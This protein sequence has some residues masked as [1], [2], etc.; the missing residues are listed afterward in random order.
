MFTYS[1]L[2]TGP[3]AVGKTCMCDLLSNYLNEENKYN[4]FKVP[5][6]LVREEG[7]SLLKLYLEKTISNTT[8]QNYILDY[9]DKALLNLEDNLKK[10]TKDNIVIYE[11]VPDDSVLCFANLANIRGEFSNRDFLEMYERTRRIDTRFSIPSYINKNVQY[12]KIINDVKDKTFNKI[13][14]IMQ[15][16]IRNKVPNRVIMLN[17]DIDTLMQR[18]R[19]RAREG[20]FYSLESMTMFHNHYEKL[21]N[22][23]ADKSKEHMRFVDVGCVM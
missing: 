2:I 19:I 17:A 7:P 14:E 1:I 16:D 12:T 15:E 4:I 9:Y 10:S 21:H 5:E 6:Y 13:K 23:M 18:M 20:E 8:F 22:Y 3:V 11:R